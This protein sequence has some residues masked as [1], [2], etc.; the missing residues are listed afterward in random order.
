MKHIK[1]FESFDVNKDD[2]QDQKVRQMSIHALSGKAEYI[3]LYLKSKPSTDELHKDL[4]SLDIDFEKINAVKKAQHYTVGNAKATFNLYANGPAVTVETT[5]TY[6]PSDK[7]IEKLKSM[8]WRVVSSKRDR[9]TFIG[10]YS[11]VYMQKG[12]YMLYTNLADDDKTT[13][14]ITLNEIVKE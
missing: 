1:L 9:G 13:S 12:E 6:V 4:K 7:I 10:G 8:G 5:T 14:I 3:V 11:V 2:A